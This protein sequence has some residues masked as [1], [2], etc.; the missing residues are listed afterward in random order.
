MFFSLKVTKSLI[1][2]IQC[3][4]WPPPVTS[5]FRSA[6][7]R[8]TTFSAS[9]KCQLDY[10]QGC[11]QDISYQLLLDEPFKKISILNGIFLHVDEGFLLKS[12]FSVLKEYI[13]RSFMHKFSHLKKNQCEVKIAVT[14]YFSPVP[15][16]KIPRK[17]TT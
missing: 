2:T 15:A 16:V 10:F 9:R 1:F 6:K 7:S 5:K 4:F 13:K 17:R 12:R 11:Y 3:P 8:C 14:I